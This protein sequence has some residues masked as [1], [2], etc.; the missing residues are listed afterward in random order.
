MVFFVR[1]EFWY[2]YLSEL[3]KRNIPVY[4]ISANFLKDQ[5]FFKWYGAFFR[6]MLKCFNIIFTQN[7]ASKEL[8]NTICIEQVFVSKD[9]RF[10]RVN[11]AVNNTRILPVIE[12]F[13][14]DKFLLVA[15]SCYIEEETLVNHFLN[16]ASAAKIKVILAPHEVDI[17]HIKSIQKT[18]SGN[19]TILYSD[20][21][22]ENV[23]EAEV[24]IIDNIGLLSSIYK[25]ADIALIGG[26]FGKKGLHNILEAA[27]FGM[28]VL[29]GPN[30]H[31]KFPEAKQL[32]NNGTAFVIH[33][34]AEFDLLLN[35]MISDK[36]KRNYLSFLSKNFITENIGATDLILSNIS[37]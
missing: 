35:E 8:L 21:N 11:H 1:Y 3:K 13:R 7:E 17:T 25:Y 16:N 37:L 31:E 28:P 5:V 10:D 22:E 9:T 2:H 12:Q 34:S 18:F 33:N 32:I 36:I 4:L 6:K 14:Q 27:A 15:G 26:G 23:K 24:I 30:N 29:F 19:K 20:A